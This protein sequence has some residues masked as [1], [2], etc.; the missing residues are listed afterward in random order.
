MTPEEILTE[1]ILNQEQRLKRAEQD[2]VALTSLLNSLAQIVAPLIKT[3]E[4][5]LKCSVCNRKMPR[6]GRKAGDICNITNLLD[7]TLCPGV[8]TTEGT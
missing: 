1:K 6:K 3:K 7:D 2:I 5:Y 8:L 4:V